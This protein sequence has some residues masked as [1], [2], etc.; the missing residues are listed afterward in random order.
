MLPESNAC[1][2]EVAV[3]GNRSLFTHTILSPRCTCNTAGLNCM[4]SMTTV[5]TAP[6]AGCFAPAAAMLPDERRN[7][8]GQSQRSRA[9]S[10]SPGRLGTALAQSRLDLLRHVEV[11]HERGP[12]LDQQ[13]LE[14]CVLG[15]R[16]QSLV[17]R[18]QHGLVVG[19]LVVDVGLVEGSAAERLQL[20]DVLIAALLEALA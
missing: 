15:T 2:A 13:R 18:I 19:D 12:H 6:C 10:V 5:C 17:Q 7:A 20:G 3:W 16:D 1:D 9:R 4:F 8:A 14:L 11:G